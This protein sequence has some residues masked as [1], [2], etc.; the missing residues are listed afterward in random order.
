MTSYSKGIDRALSNFSAT[1]YVPLNDKI[2]TEAQLFYDKLGHL[3]H[4]VTGKD[5]ASLAEYQIES[6]NGLHEFRRLLVVKS[7]KI[8]LTTSTLML[9]L[10][11]ALLPTSNPL[12]TRGYDTLLIAQTKDIAREHLRTLRKMIMESP[13]YAKYLIDSPN[14]IPEN[15]SELNFK[16]LMRSEQSKTSVIYLRNP[17]NEKQPSRIIALGTNS[18][19]SILSWRNVKHLHIS[20]PTATEGDYSEAIDNALTRLA[21]TNGS[22]IIETI[23]SGPEGKIYQMYQQYHGKEWQQGDFK[24]LTI[25][26]QEAVKAGVITQE[27]LDSEAKRLGALYPLYY[28]AEFAQGSGNIFSNE[29]ID[30]C[31]QHYD[32]AFKAGTYRIMACDPAFSKHGSK[33]AILGIEKIDG[34]YYV[35]EAREYS[36]LSTSQAISTVAR[37]FERDR[38]SILKVDS[39]FP[40]LIEDWLKGAP[41]RAE[42]NVI[43]FNFREKATTA[44]VQAAQMVNQ[45][46]VRIH[47]QFT[48]LIRQ[49]RI[50]KY[51]KD[52][53]L[54]KGYNSYD[55]IDCLSMALDEESDGEVACYDLGNDND[56][57]AEQIMNSYDPN[58]GRPYMAGFGGAY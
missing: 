29:D 27:F 36:G 20:D 4:P 24:V 44:P 34:I 57:T 41:D 14:E 35:K 46:K 45:L 55:L 23:P 11:L 9:D 33:F 26:A 48:E 51:D 52:G 37:L 18:P 32:L 3:R 28:G 42:I 6:W 2:P 53:K 15:D 21:N 8:G 5:V 17:E 10:Q 13:A 39:A 25:G 38:Y 49:M 47:P 16:K 50:C 31:I 40:G 43:P 58:S 54:E 1:N 22:A 30:L 56:W 19:G 7:N 12:S